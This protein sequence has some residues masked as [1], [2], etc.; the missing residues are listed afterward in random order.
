MRMEYLMILTGDVHAMASEMF[1]ISIENK[2]QSN[3]A[4]FKKLRSPTTAKL[5]RFLDKCESSNYQK[6]FGGGLPIN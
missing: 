6:N 4:N 1:V 3:S 2:L 5:Y